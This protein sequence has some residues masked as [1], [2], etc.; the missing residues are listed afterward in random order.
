MIQSLM[1][2]GFGSVDTWLTS[3]EIQ[4]LREELKSR[5]HDQQFELAGIGK[6]FNY[7]TE[8]AIRR[9]QILWLDRALVRPAENRFFEIVDG[10]SDY[11]NRTTYSGIRNSEFHYAMYEPGAFYKRH[12][13]QFKNDNSRM[14]SMVLYLHESWTD[15]DGGELRLYHDQEVDIQPLPGRLVVFDSRIEHEVLTSKCVRM[16]LTGWL[17]VNS[18]F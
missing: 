16:S 8:T 14:F 12:S 7:Q 13:D 18:V 3:S 6:Q 17:K 4:G 11:L 10:F 1:D 5:H 9:D 15:G 2:K